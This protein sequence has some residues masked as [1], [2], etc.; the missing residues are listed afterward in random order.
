MI[1]DNE[2]LSA[3][4]ISQSRLKKIL[5]HPFF[6]IHNKESEDDEPKEVTLIGDGVDMILTQGE[7]SFNENILVASVERPTGQM[8]D[9]VWS[10]YKNRHQEN[11]E[12]IAY[13]EAGFKRDTLAK[14][15]ERFKTE[16]QEYYDQLL[17]SET[18][19]VI[20]PSQY[21]T[22]L[23]IVESLKHNKFTSKYFMSAKFDRMY[24]V[25]LYGTWGKHKIKGL[26]DT[27]LYDYE[28]NQIYPIDIKTTSK[29]LHFFDDTIFNHRYDFQAAF[30]LELINQNIGSIAKHFECPSTPQ[31]M[32]FHF[33]V[34]SQVYPG[35]PLIFK[36]SEDAINIGRHG[37]RRR[38]RSYE[39]FVQAFERLNFHLESD[40][41]DYRKE[42]YENNGVRIV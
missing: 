3:G 11:A 2:Y 34:E 27:I 14:V 40:L 4:A 31:I 16:G 17:E 13:N 29:S 22:V 18:K 24:Q 41:W 1:T 35:N 8:G 12:E 20:S 9:Y 42:D 30:Y 38:N 28:N 10:L 37:G 39:G 19:K 33:I 36:M 26:L 25:P 7:E 6:Y 23:D 32:P 15:T 5:H 21:N